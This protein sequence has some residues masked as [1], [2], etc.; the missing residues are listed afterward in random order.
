MSKNKDKR[1]EKRSVATIETSDPHSI[2]QE[3]LRMENVAEFARYSFQLEEKREQS[4]LN[5]AGQML[6]AFS[7]SSVAVLMATPIILDH[8]SIPSCMI[9]LSAGIVLTFMLIS[10]VLAVIS[11]WRFHYK[12]MFNGKEL[13]QKVEADISRHAFQPQY[14]FQWILQLSAIQESKKKNNDIRCNLI[15][16]S[17]IAFFVAVACLVICSVI[18][19]CLQ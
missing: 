16:A 6:M 9:L 17:M 14:D 11:Q 7:V 15:Q 10:M 13:L 3:T 12:T 2:E 4:I 18:I 19:V 5:Q 8:T 1:K